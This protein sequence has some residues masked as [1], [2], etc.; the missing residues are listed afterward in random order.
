MLLLMRLALLVLLALIQV[1]AAQQLAFGSR[2]FRDGMTLQRGLGTKVW[3]DGAAPHAN[4]TVVLT[5][6]ATVSGAG[7]ASASG[8]WI[9]EMPLLTAAAST[10]VRA[11]DGHTDA[12]LTNVAVGD[13]LLCGG[14]SNM[15]CRG[16]LLP[17]CQG[18]A[19]EVGD[20][21]S[22]NNYLLDAF[23]S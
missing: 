20:T 7:A 10:M 21:Q 19:S 18:G 22:S 13:V 1:A 2:L 11:S 23:V 16:K 6:S 4:V 5:A 17:P 15:V 9:V 12:A 3:G 8:S 14:Q